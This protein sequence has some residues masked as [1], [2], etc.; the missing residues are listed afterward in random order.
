MSTA[1]SSV[2]NMMDSIPDDVQDELEIIESLYKMIRL[3]QSRR[4]VK[5][6]GTLST[7]DVREHFFNKQNI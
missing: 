6:N 3:E 4:S 2:L 1:K 7:Q 5:S